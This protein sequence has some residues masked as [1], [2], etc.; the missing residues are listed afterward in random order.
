M[1]LVEISV[2]GEGYHSRKSYGETIFLLEDDYKL[3]GKNCYELEVSLGELDG[4]HS[5]VHGEIEIEIITESDQPSYN[6]KL[7]N[8]GS[9]LY[10]E[11]S[12]F[13]N[14]LSKMI[15]RANRYISNIDSITTV[16]F[17]VRT[18]QVEQLN[19]FVNTLIK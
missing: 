16:S 6:F 11:I 17:Q 7:S 1:N 4:N 8:D 15:E 19:E 2:Y 14:D 18:S 3:L 9:R 13:T 5:E 10:W 12:A